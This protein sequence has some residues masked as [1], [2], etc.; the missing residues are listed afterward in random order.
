[1]MPYFFQAATQA[2]AV[3]LRH[4]TGFGEQLNT[5]AG[6]RSKGLGGFTERFET[7]AG[8][9]VGRWMR[10]KVLGQS[11]ENVGHI[12]CGVETAEGA[13]KASVHPSLFPF[14][15]CAE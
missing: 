11:G 4:E 6:Q 12:L 10:I 1:M 15:Q 9:L 3:E 8:G 14:C 7:L 2:A 5:V 13:T